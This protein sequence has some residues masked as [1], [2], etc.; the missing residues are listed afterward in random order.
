M[1]GLRVGYMLDFENSKWRYQGGDI[2][3]APRYGM[4][5]FYVKLTVGALGTNRL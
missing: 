5:G 3:G 1:T 2:A 4:Q